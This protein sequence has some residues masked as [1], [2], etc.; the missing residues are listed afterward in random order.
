M[1]FFFF[2]GQPLRHDRKPTWQDRLIEWWMSVRV[3]WASLI[4]GGILFSQVLVK[5]RGRNNP[6]DSEVRISL[7]LQVVWFKKIKTKTKQI[8]K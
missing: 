4:V 3:F 6:A 1:Q 2:S 5:L 8:Q 7:S